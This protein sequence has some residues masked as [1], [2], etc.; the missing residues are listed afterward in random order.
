MVV[1]KNHTFSLP[2]GEPPPIC[3]GLL[4]KL[5]AGWPR[6]HKHGPVVEQRHGLAI[7]PQ[8][9]PRYERAEPQA[10]AQRPRRA[11]TT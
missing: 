6:K 7:G 10:I 11:G 2:G 8:G 9:G 3:L 1:E 4:K 5:P